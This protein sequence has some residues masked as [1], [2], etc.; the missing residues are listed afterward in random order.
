MEADTMS[1]AELEEHDAEFVV[2]PR[3]RPTAYT[4]NTA[5]TSYEETY[6]PPPSGTAPESEPDVGPIFGELRIGD[7]SRTQSLWYVIYR[8]FNEI[9][10]LS[11]IEAPGAGFDRTANYAA[12]EAFASTLADL[13]SAHQSSS[14]GPEGDDAQRGTFCVHH[15]RKVI[16]SQNVEF[17]LQ[18]LPRWKPRIAIDR[19]TTEIDDD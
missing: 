13:L 1:I 7:S 4:T 12:T 16:F 5:T 9:A 17:H 6:T 11:D 15:E 3:Q 18:Q 8:S 19:R 10:R 2:A 14:P